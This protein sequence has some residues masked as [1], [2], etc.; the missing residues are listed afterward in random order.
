M[1]QH[2]YS[3]ETSA[4]PETIWAI[5]CDVPGWPK[6][7]GGLDHAEITGSFEAGTELNLTPSGQR[8]VTS[9]LVEVK[10]NEGFI[11]ESGHGEV[12]IRV[13]HRIERIASDRTRIVY[14]IQV[15]GPSAENIG[16]AISADF[17]DVLK[18]LA[19]FAELKK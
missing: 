9:R 11:D 2:E 8:T 14:A 12:V 3:I 15:T 5:F 1:W 6:W 18:S 10:E 16:K 17:P 7:I 19:S 4:S 13:E